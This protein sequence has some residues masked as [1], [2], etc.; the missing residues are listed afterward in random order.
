MKLIDMKKNFT[1]VAAVVVLASTAISLP[2]SAEDGSFKLGTGDS[3]FQDQ[4]FNDDV[5]GETLDL[6]AANAHNDNAIYKSLNPQ[7]DNHHF[8]DQSSAGN[9]SAGTVSNDRFS[10]SYRLSFPGRYW[11]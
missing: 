3:S 10:A 1:S 9:N 7:H 6:G 11:E 2:A 8:G 4:R 5:Y